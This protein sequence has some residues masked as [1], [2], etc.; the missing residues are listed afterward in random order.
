MTPREIAY[1]VRQA[2]LGVLEDLPG[3]FRTPAAALRA[4]AATLGP[5]L[6]GGEGRAR[7]RSMPPDVRRRVGDYA[8]DIRAGRL[9]VFGQTVSA[10]FPPSWH[11]DPVTGKEWPTV[12]AGRLDYRGGGA[13]YV[14]EIGRQEFLPVLAVQYAATGDESWAECCAQCLCDWIAHNPPRIGV[15]WTSGLEMGIRLIHWGL[16]WDLT[17]SSPAWTPERLGAL[18]RSASLQ[19][20]Y[21]R[22]HLSA[23]S[24][25]NNHLLGELAGLAAFG[26]SAPSLV[27]GTG[28]TDWALGAFWLEL[29]RQTTA[30][31]V[32]REH[33]FHY[34]AFVL[35]LAAWLW[36][37]LASRGRVPPAGVQDR[38]KRLAGFLV[39]LR[40]PSGDV[41]PVGD[42][43]DGGVGFLTRERAPGD[44]PS[45]IGALSGEPALLSS[46]RRPAELFLLVQRPPASTT[47]PPRPLPAGAWWREAGYASYRWLSGIP[48][49]LL[50]DAAPLGYLS[51]AAHGHAD[52]LSL[53]MRHGDEWVWTESGTYVYHE[54]PAWR[55][56]FRSTAAHNT[57]EVAGQDQ[58][59]QL[60]ATIWGAK[61]AARFRAVHLSP[62][63]AALMAE[64]EG[65]RRL[66]PGVV[67]RRWVVVLPEYGILVVDS[68]MPPGGHGFVQNW[69]LGPGEISVAGGAATW[70]GRRSRWSCRSGVGEAR[71][72]RAVE[73]SPLGWRSRHYGAR[74]TG[75]VISFRGAGGPATLPACT[76]WWPGA[77][78]QWRGVRAVAEGVAVDGI[79][80]RLLIRGIENDCDGARGLDVVSTTPGGERRWGIP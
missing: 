20:R 39:D 28:M 66:S 48:V 4:T 74:D 62:R 50:M 64:H 27:G 65:Y 46:G 67:H 26:L 16:V 63:G 69:H 53:W 36:A 70:Q 37:A 35:Q 43:D 77:A 40:D 52:A 31:G 73:G 51:I 10:G 24:S 5:G 29:E 8:A 75:T 15:H 12:R 72:T 68:L 56:Y 58:S 34:Q 11:R 22:R 17:R 38:L 32:T 25:A 71:L 1:R 3:G 49:M 79:G 14:W 23:H 42:A 7:V 80:E 76:W 19:A 55:A 45:W 2:A 44:V 18:A 13:K 41:I 61:A 30:D 60:G 54:H 57:L 59:E 9:T 78:D 33:A 21:I 6:L 47:A